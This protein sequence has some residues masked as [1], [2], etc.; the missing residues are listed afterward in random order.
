[1]CR[2]GPPAT[3][4]AAATIAAL[5]ATLGAR[6]TAFAETG[7]LHAAALFDRHGGAWMVREDVGRHNAVDKVVGGALAADRLP[8]GDAVL[9]VSGR[10]AYE[11]I[12]KAAVAGVAAVVAV[13]APSSLAVEAAR[14]A[15]LTLVGF[16][17]NGRFNVY[18]GH[19]R[20][21]ADSE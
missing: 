13:G 17:R 11:I 5:P 9:V 14:A 19:D 16:A 4:F 20:I 8:A 7:G 10:V 21:A 15:G 6:Q 1:V 3:A 18:T 2:P 12:H